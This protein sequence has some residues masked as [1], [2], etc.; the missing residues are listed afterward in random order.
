MD[1]AEHVSTSS[2]ISMKS[3]QEEH[4]ASVLK[5]SASTAKER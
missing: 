3:S 2:G 1:G 4:Q 5:F